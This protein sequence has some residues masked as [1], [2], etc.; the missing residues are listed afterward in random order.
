M[1]QDSTDNIQ[2]NLHENI[3]NLTSHIGS[4]IKENIGS[5]KIK[6]VKDNKVMIFGAV[7]ITILFILISRWAYDT[8]VKPLLNRDY[9]PNKEFISE[10]GNNKINVY[11]FYT[12]WCPYCKKARPEWDEFVKNLEKDKLINSSYDINFIEVDAEKDTTLAKEFKVDAYPTIKLERNGKIYNY[13]AKPNSEH[14][15]EFFKGS[16]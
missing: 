16:L 1:S 12:T 5:E 9:I 3:K 4:K 7:L 6:W 8:Y 13:D 10:T 2:K 15:M 11:F 14:L